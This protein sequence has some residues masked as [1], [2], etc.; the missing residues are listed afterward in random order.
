[1]LK[2]WLLLALILIFLVL[3]VTASP[4]KE[5]TAKADALVTA[6]FVLDVK[7][8]GAGSDREIEG[9][10]TCLMIDAKG[11]VLCS[12]TELGGYINLLGRLMGGQGFNISANPNELRITV[13]GEDLSARLVTRDSD[14]D[15]AWVQIEE[16]GERQLP[17]LDLSRS[18]T[19]EVGDSF[20][21]LRLLDKF[22]DRAPIVSE[23]IVGAIV[24]KPR[25]LY[26][27]SVPTSSGFGLPAFNAAGELIG[28]SIMPGM[29]DVSPRQLSNPLSFIGD[30]VKMQDM[31]GGLIL[32]AADAH[33]ATQLV[34]ELMQEEA[35]EEGGE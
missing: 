25:R 28:I 7:M 35:A 11:L 20:Y 6:K 15:L 17:F 13:D 14:R 34:H 2:R 10:I 31:V 29:E 5:L 12:N 8:E 18:V 23:A 21:R 19:P 26:V 24:D 27:P 32:P 4:F 3:P 16:V 9:E 22:F 30:S 33:K 1:M